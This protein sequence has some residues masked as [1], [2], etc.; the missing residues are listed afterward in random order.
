MGIIKTKG[1]VLAENN[2]GDF[3]KMITL[4]T[5]DCGKIGCSAKGARRPKS[6]LMAGTQFLCFGEYMIYKSANSYHIN[7]CDP[8]EVFYNIRIDLNKL[9]YAS[10]IIKIIIDVTDENEG[11]YRI[12]QLLLNTLYII[13][14]TNRDLDFILSIFKIRLVCILGFTPNT[15]ECTECGKKEDF[16]YFSF[17]NEGFKCSDCGK[18]DK[19]AIRI[20]ETTVN[21]IQ[22]IIASTPK[23]IFSFNI[24]EESKKE[25]ELIANVYLNDKLEK[26]YKL[27][28]LF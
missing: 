12:L 26:E 18:V 22:Y 20:S 24:P 16:R 7:S 11:N 2:M 1:I 9:K 8:I 17:K 19:S 14:E 25:L 4:F 27:E 21:A 28:E 13:S 10:H 3:D 6:L 5:P 15:L 23:K